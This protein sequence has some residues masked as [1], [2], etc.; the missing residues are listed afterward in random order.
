MIEKAKGR[1]SGFKGMVSWVAEM[2][3]NN[4]EDVVRP[5]TMEKR[6]TDKDGNML[7]IE[8]QQFD[9]VENTVTCGH[10]DFLR[11]TSSTRKFRFNKDVVNRLI[12]GVYIQKLIENGK[13]RKDVQMVTEEPGFYDIE[14]KIENTEDIE[15]NGRKRCAYRLC[16]GLK[17]GLFD[18][19]KIF[20]PK[21]YVWHSAEPKFEWLRYKGVESSINSPKVEITTLEQKI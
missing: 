19:V 4:T 21:A 6:V 15:I 11:N 17:L 1:Y 2:E 13:T 7:A 14:L 16:L 20:L 18:F 10:D 8:K 9:F 3:F 5:I 12:L